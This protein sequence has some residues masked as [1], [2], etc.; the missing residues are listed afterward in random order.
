MVRIGI[1]GLG[2]NGTMHLRGF[3]RTDGCEVV[4]ACD[5]LA[6]KRE[7]AARLMQDKKINLYTSHKAM[8][9]NETLDAVAISTPTYMHAPIA[10]DALDAGLDIHLEK[11]IAPTM[12]ETDALIVRAFEAGR[13]V[14]VGLVYR[15]SNLFRTV[16]RLVERGDFGNVMMA[17]CKEYRDNFPTQWFFETKKSGGAILD[18]N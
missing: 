1:I 6:E 16:G 7:L 4:A 12:E 11:P 5:P 9:K 13:I 2:E 18:K 3:D 14:Q 17:Y 8:F 10:M 15:Y